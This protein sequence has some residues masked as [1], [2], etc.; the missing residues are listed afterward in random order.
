MEVVAAAT[1]ALP[2]SPLLDSDKHAA[3]D[4]G[5]PGS[6]SMHIEEVRGDAGARGGGVGAFDLPWL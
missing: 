1:A 2:A 3:E 6:S 4:G 5:P